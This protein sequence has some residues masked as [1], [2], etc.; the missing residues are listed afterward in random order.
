MSLSTLLGERYAPLTSSI[1][2]VEL[3]FERASQAFAHWRRS[4]GETRVD[5]SVGPFP[6]A[7]LRLQPLV[8]GA[9]P[10]ELLVGHGNWT[11]YFAGSLPAADAANPVA[12]ISRVSKCRGLAIEALRY[13][14]RGT[15]GRVGPLASMQWQL[16]GP[17]GG[18]F[19]NYIRTIAL[20][21]DGTRWEFV[22]AGNPQ[23]FERLE[24]YESK[25]MSDRFSPQL[26]DEY[27]RAVGVTPFDASTY[28][29]ETLLIN[30]DVQLPLD[31]RQM[32]L[33]EAQKLLGIGPMNAASS[34][35]NPVA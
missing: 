27:S 35:S 15:G 34:S 1:G 10:R 6:D 21:Y 19:L 9:A 11:A 29:P 14:G 3:P 33:A 5:D 28:G 25:R 4:L 7:L 12:H 32:S 16:F 30:S 20:V 23:P 26:I 2:F 13:E 17:H 24:R 18:P 8:A 22:A 31:A